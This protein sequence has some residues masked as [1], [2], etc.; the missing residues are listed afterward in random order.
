MN[1][2]KQL[3]LQDNNYKYFT[4]INVLLYN[5]YNYFCNTLYLINILYWFDKL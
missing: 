1:S 3:S 2:I 4:K 5:D